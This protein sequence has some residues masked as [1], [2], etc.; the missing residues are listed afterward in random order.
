MEQFKQEVT[1]LIQ[2]AV[3]DLRAEVAQQ[4]H[5]PALARAAL[6]DPQSMS[7]SLIPH[8]SA[9][10]NLLEGLPQGPQVDLESVTK[11]FKLEREL[12][13]LASLLIAEHSLLDIQTTMSL[14][15]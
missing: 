8:N 11:I 14:A 7:P 10:E 12:K 4:Q 2:Q 5:N 13:Q 15:A 3:A 9:W 6:L 1:I